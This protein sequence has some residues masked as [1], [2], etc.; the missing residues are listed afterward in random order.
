M[1]LFQFSHPDYFIS[2]TD[3]T[4]TIYD[5]TNSTSRLTLT[6]LYTTLNNT[7]KIQGDILLNQ[8]STIGPVAGYTT[9]ASD[10]SGIFLRLGTASSHAYLVLS[11]L[12][13]FRNFTLP[14]ATGTF[15]LTS[16]LSAYLP[17]AGGTMSGAITTTNVYL[18]EQTL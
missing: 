5:V 10:A 4:F 16:D 17:L 11:G 12:T 14:D 9:I 6:N 18:T 7:V 1:C 15:A 2:N 3:G 13:S 8:D